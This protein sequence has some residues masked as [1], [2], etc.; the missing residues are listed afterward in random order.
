MENFNTQHGSQDQVVTNA[1]FSF[2]EL[3]PFLDHGITEYNVESSEVAG[4][5]RTNPVNYIIETKLI[6]ALIIFF[7]VYIFLVHSVEADMA[8]LSDFDS[9]DLQNTK[10]QIL[11]ALRRFAERVEHV[12]PNGNNRISNVNRNVI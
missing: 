9:A 10:H 4:T 7:F 1:I 11:A 3:D 5:P 2:G 8:S 12:D 6:I